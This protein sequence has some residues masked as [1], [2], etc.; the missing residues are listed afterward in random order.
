[1]PAQWIVLVRYMSVLEAVIVFV[2]SRNLF[3]QNS[4]VIINITCIR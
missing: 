1:M 2:Q 3:D 4:E